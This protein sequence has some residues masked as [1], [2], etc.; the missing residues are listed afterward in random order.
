MEHASLVLM[1]EQRDCCRMEILG[2]EP[3]IADL[4]V[5]SPFKVPQGQITSSQEQAMIPQE[6]INVPQVIEERRE[7]VT[8]HRK[9]KNTPECVPC[10]ECTA[11]VTYLTPEMETLKHRSES[12]TLYIDYPTGIYDVRRDFHNN[13]SE[14][15]KLDSLMRP[16]TK[17][18]LASISD[19]FI[20]GYASPDGTYKDNE[21]LASNRARCFREYMCATYAPEHNLYKVSSVP[22]DWDGLV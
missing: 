2:V 5:N 8:D 11:M 16:L 3:L 14:L 9:M 15:E 1:R 20:C 10:A 7:T 4:A 19:I 17:G 13:R 6:Q 12:A 22:E 21:I 18:N